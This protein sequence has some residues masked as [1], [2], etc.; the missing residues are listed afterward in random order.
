MANTLAT[1]TWVVNETG[2][3][4]MNSVKGV[5]NFNRTYDDSYKVAGAPVG[6]TILARL[7]V[8][9]QAVR[10]Q[11]WQPQ[12]LTD[13]TTPITLSYQ[14]QVGYSG[15]SAEYTLEL[16][17]IRE[18][19]VN[20]AAD[21]LAS[22]ADAQGM[23][24]VYQSVYNVIGTPGTTPSTTLS[25]LQAV[26]KILDGAG[27]DDGLKAV[28][29]TMAA[30]TIANTTTTLFN[31]T[32]TISE[33]YRRGRL[34]SG[35]LGI[36]EWFQDQLVPKHTTGSAT[37]ASSPRVNGA[38]Q[39]GSSLVTSGWGAGTANLKKGD[40]ITIAGVFGVNPLSYTSTGRLQQFV[41]TADVS[42]AAGAA[43]LSISPSIITSGPLQTVTNSPANT[44]VITY[45][46][47]ADGGT[48][49]ATVSPQSLVFHP[50]F[51]AFVMVDLT[52]PV[53]GAKATFA[54]SRDFGISIR[55]VQQYLLGTD[56]NGSRLD[57]LFGAAPLQ[58]RL[59]TRVVG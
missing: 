43:T 10:G 1:P 25:Y 27:P 5:A 49:A 48:Q 13:V 6:A 56:Q 18:R 30:A 35:Q 26:V 17:R 2:L 8:R 12:A 57:I 39:T 51:A 21:A 59:A 46:S 20:P 50:D 37:G 44:A 24:D 15:S 23:L 14:S 52:D 33:N 41:L 34:G 9:M 3:R 16:D 47:M 7:P 55:Y 19:Y 29:D 38:G 11:A 58:P 31:P 4:F 54:R 53:G 45:L 32:S 28:L 22:D 40:W 42:D 36:S